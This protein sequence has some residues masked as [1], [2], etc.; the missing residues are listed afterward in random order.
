MSNLKQEDVVKVEEKQ[1]S[2]RKLIQKVRRKV[3]REEQRIATS[4][5]NFAK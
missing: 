4:Y 1:T 5:G 3:K 2:R